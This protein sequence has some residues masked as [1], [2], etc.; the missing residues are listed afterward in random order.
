MRAGVVLLW[1]A[2]TAAVLFGAGVIAFLLVSQQP[3]IIP[4][5]DPEPTTA[6]VV[7]PTYE[8]LILNGTASQGLETAAKDEL[9]AAGWSAEHVSANSSSTTDFP[10]TTVYYAAPE[11][12]AAAAGVAGALGGA[13]LEESDAYVSDP[14]EKLVTVVLGLDRISVE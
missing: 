8:V 9:V 6:A 11:H 2:L 1:S 14:A 12:E 3:G 5:P 10:E 4:Q 7:D 13:R